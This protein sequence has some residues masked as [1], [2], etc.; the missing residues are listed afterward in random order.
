V[1][2]IGDKIAFIYEGNLWWEGN[3]QDVL[4]SDNKELD[5]FIFST[6]LTKRIK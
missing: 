2:N 3:K 4:K 1:L 6:E 5:T